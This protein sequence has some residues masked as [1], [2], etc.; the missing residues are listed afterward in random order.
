MLV[1]GA[2]PNPKRY[3]FLATEM[4]L[5]YGHHVYPFGIRKGLIGLKAIEPLWPINAVFDT[6]TMY[7]GPDL[8]PDF[9]QKIIALKPKRIIFNPGT[10]NEAF[11]SLLDKNNI[12]YLEACTLVLLRTGQF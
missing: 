2:S 9:S 10:E 3:S 12:T 11:Y 7:I 4:L 6:V 5:E 1:I 8:Q